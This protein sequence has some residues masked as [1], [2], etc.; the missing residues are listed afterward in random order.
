VS[1]EEKDQLI[2]TLVKQN[3]TLLKQN[4]ALQLQL[5]ELQFQLA[6]LR[7]IIFGSK[8]ERFENVVIPNQTNLF[9]SQNDQHLT[10]DQDT[11][12]ATEVSVKPRISKSRKGVKRNKFP[13]QLRRVEEIIIPQDIDLENYIEIGKDITEILVVQEAKVYVRKIIRPKLKLKNKELDATIIQSPIPPRI[14]PKGMVDESV[15]AH[16]INQKIQFHLPLYR[17]SKQFKQMGLGFI[18]K[19]NI[20]SWYGAG[21]CAL[22]PL[23]H[24]LVEEVM[25]QLYLQVDESGI[26][27]LSKNKPGSTHRGQMWVAHAPV[28]KAV[29]FHYDPSRSEQAGAKFL[30]GFQGVYIQSDGYQ[31]Y[32]NIAR[33]KELK[34]I[35]CH[36][37]SRRKFYE[38]AETKSHVDLCNFY[39]ENIQQLYAIERKAREKGL[40]HEERLE[41]RKKESIPILKELKKWLAKQKDNL[42]IL[43]SD[44]L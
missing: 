44:R 10:E 3:E 25:H 26:K 42:D 18:R 19:T 36:A 23:Y 40:N 28:S 41:L 12:T 6:Q 43:P 4:E 30:A 27:V 11:A 33:K 20:E 9:N 39:I 8:R 7:K 1:H 5:K 14:L 16:I 29:L 32:E 21:V 15:M 13:E 31:V 38:A 17:Q 2:E 24:L 37:H 22:V 35:F 34:L